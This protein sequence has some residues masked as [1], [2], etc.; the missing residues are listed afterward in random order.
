[1]FDP[2]KRLLQGKSR[3]DKKKIQPY[4]GPTTI[5]SPEG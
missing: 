4:T 3:K 1:M 5:G 2:M